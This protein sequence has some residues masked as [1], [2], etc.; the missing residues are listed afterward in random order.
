MLQRLPLPSDPCGQ[1]TM[2]YPR[3]LLQLLI[4]LAL[5]VAPARATWACT[6]D[7]GQCGALASLWA[8]AGAPAGAIWAQSTGW[9]A[10][11]NGTPTPLCTGFYGVSC[12]SG[13]VSALQLP[14]NGLVGRL[15]DAAIQ[16]L[17]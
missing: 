6:G 17:C 5:A 7:A 10:A 12:T 9:S 14:T 8:S 11:A 16:P 1:A 2:T 4:L 13:L 15:P 3:P